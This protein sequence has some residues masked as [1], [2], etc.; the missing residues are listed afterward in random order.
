MP[1]PEITQLQTERGNIDLPAGGIADV[2]S[3]VGQPMA[4][5]MPQPEELQQVAM[6]IAGTMGEQGQ[7]VIDM[8]IEKYGPEVFQQI[9][10]MVLQ[11]I[12]P[13]AQTEGMVQGPGG[14]MDDQVPGVIGAGQ[15]VAVSPGE[16]IVPADVVS[17]LGDGSSDA[18]A[19]ELDRMAENVRMARG[20]SAVQPPA[21]DAKRVMP[22]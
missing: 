1:P 22:A 19:T 20:G 9:R 12:N 8:F 3:A 7:Q 14:G 18:G 2:P 11:A 4:R 10:E 13:G 16:Y 5:E 17:G 15:E 21:I 6:A